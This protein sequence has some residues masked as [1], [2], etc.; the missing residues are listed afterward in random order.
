MDIVTER[1]KSIKLLNGVKDKTLLYMAFAGTCLVLIT[2]TFRPAV[3]VNFTN[4]DIPVEML[5]YTQTSPDIPII[6]DG[7]EAMDDA[8]KPQDRISITIDQTSGFTWPWSWYLRDYPHVDYPTYGPKQFN[9]APTTDAV[10]IHSDNNKMA[11]HVLAKDFKEGQRVPHRWWFPENNYRKTP[12]R[13][14]EKQ[15]KMITRLG[16]CLGSSARTIKNN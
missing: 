9:N 1:R 10:L 3:I 11:E 16:H 15:L 4:G 8:K 13:L 5:V 2:L 7:F 14:G 12:N 6:L